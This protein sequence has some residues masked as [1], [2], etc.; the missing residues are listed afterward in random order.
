MT[1]RRAWPA[2]V[3]LAAI[4]GIVVFVL[5]RGRDD[6][7]PSAPAPQPSSATRSRPPPAP[8]ARPAEVTPPEPVAAQRAAEEAVPE[9][10]QPMSEEEKRRTGLDFPPGT[11]P[12]F[13]AA[14]KAQRHD[15]KPLDYDE[16]V[17]KSKPF[18]ETLALREELLEREIADAEKAG[19]EDKATRRRLELERVRQRKQELESALAKGKLP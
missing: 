5:V 8:V 11:D 12:E 19:D 14:V 3:G 6:E 1:N 4:T 9:Q 16:M 15:W 2:L 13:V 10:P 17:A 18:L 7:Q